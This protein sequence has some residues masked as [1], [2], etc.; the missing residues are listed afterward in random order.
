[1]IDVVRITDFFITPITKPSL[2]LVLVR[3]VSVSMRPARML[4]ARSA[5]LII[6]ALL[7]WVFVFPLTLG[8]VHNIAIV[9]SIII[10]KFPD[11]GWFSFASFSLAFS[12]LLKVLFGVIFSP[13]VATLN[14]FLTI[15]NIGH[16]AAAEFASLARWTQPITA[17]FLTMKIFSRSRE[18]LT[19]LCAAFHRGIHSVSLSL[20]LKW[21]SADGEIDRRF[22]LQSLAD[23]MNYTRMKAYSQ[24]ENR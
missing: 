16:T 2:A 18:L 11:F 17:T 14:H 9:S 4:Y 15:G 19:A 7:V 10:E 8:A 21:V 20:Y 13:L 12:Q 22:A 6:F 1:M 5:A 23:R 3:Y 24:G